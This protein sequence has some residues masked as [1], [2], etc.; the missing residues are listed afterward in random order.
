MSETLKNCPFCGG[1]DIEIL[2]YEEEYHTRNVAEC[3][4]CGARGVVSSSIDDAIETW[5]TRPEED[6]LKAENEALFRHVT[7]LTAWLKAM[8]DAYEE[9]FKKNVPE[10]IV[11]IK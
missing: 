2:T 5:N 8:E 11:V 3:M 1:N 7:G 6:R 4:D 10:K 9:L